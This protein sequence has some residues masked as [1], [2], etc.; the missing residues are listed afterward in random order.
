[1]ILVFSYRTIRWCLSVW[2]QSPKAYDLLRSG[3]IL[4]LPSGKTLQR[5]KNSLR[6]VPGRNYDLLDWMKKEADRLAIDE[7]GRCGGI[8]FDEMY[9]QVYCTLYEYMA[10]GKGPTSYYSSGLR[11]RFVYHRM[12]LWSSSVQ[13]AWQSS[14]AWWNSAMKVKTWSY[15]LEVSN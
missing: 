11:Y 15:L 8:L 6:Q 4:T 5:F 14:W 2:N 7:T 3:D 1:M 12:A 10:N 9:I 13:M